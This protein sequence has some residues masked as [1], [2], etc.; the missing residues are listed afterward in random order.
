M[1]PVAAAAARVEKGDAAIRAREAS[2]KP[3]P[4]AWYDAYEGAWADLLATWEA[5]HAPTQAGTMRQG[6]MSI[7]A[8]VR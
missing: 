5:Q 7:S 6:Q 3:V 8:G 4:D 2:G 1:T